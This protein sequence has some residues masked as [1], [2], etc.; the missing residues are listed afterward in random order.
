MSN[1]NFS[2]FINCPI[3]PQYKRLFRGIIFAIKYCGFNP[4]SSEEID[5]SLS[6]R[7]NNICN[8]I[9]QSKY[10]IHDLSRTEL[11]KNNFPRFNMPFELGL[12][13]GANYFGNNHNKEKMCLIL[14]KKEHDY[15]KYISDISGQDVKEHNNKVRDIITGI[16]DW[17]V[18]SPEGENISIPDG[19]YIYKKYQDFEKDLPEMCKKFNKNHNRLVFK[20]RVKLTQ[21]WLEINKT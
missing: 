6:I 12:F 13:I 4:R 19:Y 20:E 10:G 3:D 5:N 2:I 11:A 9:N 17:L 15:D 8:L 7:L 14:V 21:A 16:R 18:S 1:Y